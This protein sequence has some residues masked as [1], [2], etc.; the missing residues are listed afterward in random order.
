[1]GNTVHKFCI[2][3]ATPAEKDV[4]AWIDL[5]LLSLVTR[6]AFHYGLVDWVLPKGVAIWTNLQHY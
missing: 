5:D 3:G 4:L 2:R 6:P 1:M